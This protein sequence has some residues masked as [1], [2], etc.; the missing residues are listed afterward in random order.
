MKFEHRVVKITAFKA[1][2]RARGTRIESEFSLFDEVTTE[3]DTQAW[4]AV[5]MELYEDNEVGLQEQ[6]EGHRRWGIAQERGSGT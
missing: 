6:L 5:M 3:L 4:L 1:G 2:I